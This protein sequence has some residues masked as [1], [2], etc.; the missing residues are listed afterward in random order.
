LAANSKILELVLTLFVF[1][2]R[3]F[4]FPFK[5]HAMLE[6]VQKEGNDSI[7]SWLPDGNSFR[8]HKPKEFAEYVIPRYFNQTKYRSFQRQLHI[9]GFERIR[10]ENSQGV[11]AYYYHKLF[12]RGKSG[13][14]RQM[15]RQTVKGTG[16]TKVWL[17]KEQYKKPDYS[18]KNQKYLCSD[19]TSKSSSR[20]TAHSSLE[21]LVEKMESCVPLTASTTNNI[22]H[23][24]WVNIAQSIMSD[25]TCNDTPLEQPHVSRHL[26]REND[27][28]SNQCKDGEESFFAGKRFFLTTDCIKNQ[29]SAYAA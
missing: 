27:L 18:S 12:V 11:R 13:L 6:D 21:R 14:C 22:E 3:K 23:L 8:I 19:E 20:S 24:K 1:S 7:V 25:D 17:D 5:I 9:Y 26:P 4:T 28:V 29:S 16:T 15:T 2:F 10:D